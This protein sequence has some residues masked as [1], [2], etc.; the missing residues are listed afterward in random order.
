MLPL[1]FVYWLWPAEADTSTLATSALILANLIN[2]P[3][4]A[5]SYQ[6]FY[7]N[8]RSRVTSEEFCR[9][10]RLRYIFAALVV[11]FLLCGF[12]AYCLYVRSPELLGKGA[13]LM[14]FLVGWHYVKQGFGMLMLDAAL[15]KNYFDATSKKL[16]L[17]NAYAVWLLSY[18]LVNKAFH[19]KDLW[20]LKYY[21]FQP[22]D[23]LVAGMAGG[24]LL[25]SISAGVVL[26]L[27]FKSSH[28]PASRFP[29]SGVAAYFVSLYLWLLVRHPAALLIIPALH[30]LQYLAVV[31][32]YQLNFDAAHRKPN[33]PSRAWSGIGSFLLIGVVLGYLGFWAVPSW[34]TSVFDPQETSFGSGLFLFMFW[35]FINI[36]HYFM[37]NVLWRKENPDTRRYLFSAR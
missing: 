21:S 4:F 28:A 10:F 35:V 27:K 30:S 37:D 23:W 3:H 5:H 13:N 12:F 33:E 32:R 6:L 11:P 20:N 7:R 22:P 9:S 31:W 18:L 1:A 2:H 19:E 17:T 8:F 34:L 24:V 15:K 26:A 36:H 25:T 16:L 14:L 29:L